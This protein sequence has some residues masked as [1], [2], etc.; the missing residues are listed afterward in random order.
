MR[1]L[2]SLLLVVLLAACSGD[3][4]D[5]SSQAS[6]SIRVSE[7]TT[8][9]PYTA[10]Q[11]ATLS[12]GRYIFVPNVAYLERVGWLI[13]GKG[14]DTGRSAPWSLNSKDTMFNTARL[15]D[16]QHTITARYFYKRGGR[17]WMESVSAT[18]TV[19]NAAPAPEPEPPPPAPEPEPTPTDP[20]RTLI[21]ADEFSGT[22]LDRSRWDDCYPWGNEGGYEGN[23]YNRSTGET[24]VYL[25][26]NI[27]V[28]D[29]TLKLTAK[30]E[31]YCA[32]SKCFSY[33]S[34]MV[35]THPR[36]GTGFT[37]RYGYLEASIKMPKGKGLWPAFWTL[38]WPVAHPPE[39]DITE[40]LGDS[41]TTHRMHYHYDDNG[42]DRSVGKNYVGPDLSAD[43]HTYA[44]D[45]RPGLIVWYFDGVEVFRT[46][47]SVSGDPMYLLLNLAVDGWAGPP[48]SSTPFPAVMEVDWVRVYR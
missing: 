44:V 18:F 29:G 5:L 21:F 39:I 48:D 12:D 23:C 16:G 8:G 33:T 2:S 15:A 3:S 24:Q 1:K 9:S 26:R 35:A 13:D 45:W 6:P 22:S 41:I 11:G 38:P 7:S 14:Y 42:T 36:L 47:Q 28:A 10:L 20:G 31:N 25:E 34:G 40:V 27:T 4:A 17:R 37:T 30:R 46:T 19:R 32:H 43:F